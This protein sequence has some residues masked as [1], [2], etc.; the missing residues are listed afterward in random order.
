MNP[1]LPKPSSSNKGYVYILYSHNSAFIKIGGTD[2]PPLKRIREI[3]SSEPYKTLGPWY[4]HDFRE[5]ENWRKIESHLHYAFRSNLVTEVLGQKELFSI[6]PHVAA[7]ALDG[8]KPED[9]IGK[10][11]VD[12]LF[13]DSAFSSYAIK[14]F[15]FTGL[16][17]WLE[18]QGAWTFVLFP[19]TGGGRYFTINI[20]PHEVAFSTIARS[21]VFP[22]HMI[23]MDKLILD[24][25]KVREWV[26]SHSGDISLD[27]YTSALPRSASVHFS[28]SLNEALEFFKLDGVRRAVTAY[29]SE[30]LIELSER[31]KLSTYSRYHN[32]NAVS[33]IHRRVSRSNITNLGRA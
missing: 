26:A 31:S 7:T 13:N 10:P 16:S 2:Y 33:Q 3:N 25:P 29:W 15:I 22:T 9:I 8:I 20:G 17:N 4:L 19:K 27:L 18:L 32:W 21:G 24:F 1:T 28:C 5:V 30:A 23:L 12:R 11:K 14:L 6:S